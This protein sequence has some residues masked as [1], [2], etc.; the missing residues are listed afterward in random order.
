MQHCQ[1]TIKSEYEGLSTKEEGKWVVKA[2]MIADEI[3]LT[4]N[5]P[6]GWNIIFDKNPTKVTKRFK[7]HTQIVYSHSAINFLIIDRSKKKRLTVSKII[8]IPQKF[9]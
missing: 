6:E 3:V 8:T 2:K 9:K 4:A 7:P 1:A 5:S